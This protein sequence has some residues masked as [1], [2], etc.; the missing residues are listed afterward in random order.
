MA[1]G[2]KRR[3]TCDFPMAGWRILARRALDAIAPERTGPGRAL[4]TGRKDPRRSLGG[5]TKAQGFEIGNAQWA[6]AQAL[7]V[8][9]ALCTGKCNVTERIGARVTE[10]PGVLGAAASG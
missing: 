3:R 4:E 10:A 7:A 2:G 1:P 8:S 9:S 5:K 6:S